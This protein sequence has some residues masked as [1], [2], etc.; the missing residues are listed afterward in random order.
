[1][2]PGSPRKSSRIASVR[3]S[4][5]SKGTRAE[6]SQNFTGPPR[7]QPEGQQGHSRPRTAAAVSPSG[8]RGEVGRSHDA[9]DP[10]VPA[11]QAGP[12]DRP[13]PLVRIPG[14]LPDAHD[15]G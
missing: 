8:S 3:S 7:A 2:I 5:T 4:S 14:G 1:M 13:P 15:R 11:G 12:Q 9:T 10:G 6:L